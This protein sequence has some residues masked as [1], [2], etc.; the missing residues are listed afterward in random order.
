MSL[1]AF[2]LEHH[3]ISQMI[4]QNVDRPLCKASLAL[5][6]WAHLEVEVFL[7]CTHI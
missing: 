4:P 5:H 1:D 7:L 2:N 6:W 3:D